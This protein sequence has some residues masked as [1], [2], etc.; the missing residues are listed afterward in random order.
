MLYLHASGLDLGNKSRNIISLLKMEDKTVTTSLCKL[1][2][3][4]GVGGR[5]RMWIVEY[6][7]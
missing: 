4:A 5:V 3:K 6:M 7:T 1:L 2:Y